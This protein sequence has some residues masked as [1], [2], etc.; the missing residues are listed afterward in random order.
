MVT[1]Y[2]RGLTN[3]M[4]RA[5]Q[6]QESLYEEVERDTEATVQALLV[7]VVVALATGVGAAIGAGPRAGFA[8]LFGNL[9][10]SVIVWVVWSLIAYWIGTA[11]FGG[12]ATPGELLRTI[13]FAH[14]PGVLRLFSFIPVLG[15]FINFGVAIWLLIAGVIAVRQ[16]LDFSTGKAIGTVVLGWLTMVVLTLVLGGLLSGL[17]FLMG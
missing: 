2:D 5:A 4:I 3:R 17:S 6:L 9:V 16:A 8:A 1:S 15:F 11:V 12:T 14:S 10:L 7:V 13:G